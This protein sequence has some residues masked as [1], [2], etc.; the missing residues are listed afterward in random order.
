MRRMHSIKCQDGADSALHR[1]ESLLV[2]GSS[3]AAVT[4]IYQHSLFA[5]DPSN[6]QV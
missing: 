1:N 4:R 5:L 3:K 6:P 2:Y